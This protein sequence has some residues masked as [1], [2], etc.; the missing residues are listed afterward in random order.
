MIGLEMAVLILSI[1]LVLLQIV[2]E[3]IAIY[4]D[5]GGREPGDR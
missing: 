5:T 4:K 2:H 1:G 3:L